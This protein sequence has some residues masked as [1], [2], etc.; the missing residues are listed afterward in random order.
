MDTLFIADLH[1][2]DDRPEKFGL[3]K[4]LL[5][6]PARRASAVY[7]L[8]D[9]FESFWLGND[10]TTSRHPE[11]LSELKNFTAGGPPLFILRGNRELLLDQGIER[12]TGAVMLPE[13]AL[14]DLAGNPVLV[15]HG[16]LLCTRDTGYQL[17]RRFMESAPV[18]RFFLRLPYTIRKLLIT[19]LRPFFKQSVR[20][21][22]PEIMDVDPGA[23]IQTM[24]RH[25][26]R[27]LIHGHTHRPGIHI[28]DID[29]QPARRIVLGD[30]YEHELILVCRGN[31]RKLMSITDYLSECG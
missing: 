1:L 16:D 30:W 17:Y 23:V 9:L 11:I 18:K 12:L 24:R 15:S 19:S 20:N 14:I 4:Q 26:V 29:N 6:G 22:R 8:G 2:S 5:R 25:H 7:I 27:E 21:K 31:D 10:D 13:P 28:L 3:F